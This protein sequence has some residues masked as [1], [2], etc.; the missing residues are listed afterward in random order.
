MRHLDAGHPAGRV[1]MLDEVA[2]P[3][4]APPLDRTV[5]PRPPRQL[6]F[7]RPPEP[8]HLADR[9]GH[10]DHPAEPVPLIRGDRTEGIGHRDGQAGGVARHP[11]GVAEGVG[12][13]GEPAAVVIGEPGPRP[14]R[15]DHR[16]QVPALVVR[17]FPAGTV[18]LDQRHR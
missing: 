14:D 5:R 12:D 9:V 10:R 3:V 6:P 1:H 13:G 17:A 4:I 7:D 11:P 15:I 8:G 18:R 16:G 2:F